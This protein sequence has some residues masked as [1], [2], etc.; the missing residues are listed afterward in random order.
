MT[1]YARYPDTDAPEIVS[2]EEILKKVHSSLCYGYANIA[3]YMKD[4]PGELFKTVQVLW[5]WE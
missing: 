5:W 1:F 3:E 2:E 4:H